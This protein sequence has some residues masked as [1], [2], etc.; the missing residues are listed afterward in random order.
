MGS[1]LVIGIGRFGGSL[2][3]ELGRMKHEVLAVD[4]NE[5]NVTD[6]MDEVTEV[7]VGDAT[8]DAVLASLGVQNF[9]CV[10]VTLGES[11]EDSILTTMLLKEMGAQMLVCKAQSSL[12]A[13]ILTQIGADKVIRP[14]HDMGKRVAHALAQRNLM[15]YLELSSDFAILELSTPQK[16]VDS[17]IINTRMR[18]KYGC[19]LVAINCVVKGEIEISPHPETVLHAGD[20]LTLVGHRDQ[21]DEVSLLG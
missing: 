19:F 10:V 21:L 16:W 15:N 9:D 13:K 7:I 8:D 11:I 12:H 2:A 3:V 1:F 5:D 18:E 17:T 20:V 14:E 4:K 6:I